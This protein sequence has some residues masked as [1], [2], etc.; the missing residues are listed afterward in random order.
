MRVCASCMFLCLYAWAFM[1]KAEVGRRA[2]TW[3]TDMQKLIAIVPELH[4]NQAELPEV[5]TQLK[6]SEYGIFL[7]QHDQRG[8]G[9]A[10]VDVQAEPDPERPRWMRR[11]MWSWNRSEYRC[12]DEKKGNLQTNSAF[13]CCCFICTYFDL[14]VVCQPNCRLINFAC[15][16]GYSAL[17][18]E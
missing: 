13:C 17:Q 4:L 2:L 6:G 5:C 14:Y 11:K 15:V 1:C 12:A 7:S 18:R 9:Q 8:A 16:G 3:S 10:A